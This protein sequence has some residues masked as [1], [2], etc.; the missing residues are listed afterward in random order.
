VAPAAAVRQ[1]LNLMSTWEVS[2]LPVL[3]D[4]RCVGSLVE[5]SLM[6]KALAQPTLLDRPVREVM[7]AAFPEVDAAAPVDR[8][9]QMLT[10]ES[11]AALVRKG[12]QLIGIVSR[13]DIL[14][15]MIGTR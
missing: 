7:E 8:V 6:T 2:Q 9:A 1:A 3:E 13:Y 4:G 5:S 14:Q 15:Q 10:R 11:P 12:G